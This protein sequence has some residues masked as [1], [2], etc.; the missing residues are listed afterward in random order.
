MH[1]KPLLAWLLLFAITAVEAG[2]VQL[3]RSVAHPQHYFTQGLIIH[4]GRITE[5]TG[6]YGHSLLA[7]YAL[8]GAPQERLHLPNHY[9]GEGVTQFGNHL[10]WLSWRAGKAFQID[11]RNFSISRTFDYH[12]Q[13]WGITHNDHQLIMSNGS[14]ILQ[15]KNPS[16]FATEATIGVFDEGQPVH[17]LNEL[18]WVNGYILANIWREDRIVKIDPTNGKV[19]ARYDLRLLR[20]SFFYP[21]AD[22]LNGIAFDRATGKL[23]VTGKY[24]PL[25]FEIELQD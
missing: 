8:G 15:F 20:R 19:V 9:F 21:K 16:T 7:T 4:D 25:L 6:Q 10:Y 17:R 11:A 1:T 12:G 14:N 22:A 13:G 18:E 23:Y 5:T 24:W 3:V 2:N